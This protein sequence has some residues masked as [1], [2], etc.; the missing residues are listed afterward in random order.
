MSK[1]SSAVLV[2]LAIT[3]SMCG[4]PQATSSLDSAA[5]DKKNKNRNLLYFD[6]TANFKR[7]SFQDSIRYYL[8]KSKDAGV[9]DVVVDVKPI[10][11]EVLYPSKIAPVMNEWA[12][13]TK[14]EKFDLLT[15][16]IQ[17]AHQ[18]GMTVHA[19]TNIFVAGHNHFNRGPVYADP[20]KKNWQ[21]LNYTPQGM[22]PITQ[23][24]TKYSAMVNP[25]L[26]E[27]Q[28]YE[29]SILKEL[30]TRYPKLDGVILD[31]VR[32]DGLESDFSQASRQAFEKH[33]GRP[34]AKFP[35]DIYTYSKD[36]KPVRVPGPLFKQW[37][38]WRAKVIYDFV[39]QA[40]TELK[41]INPKLIFGD[42]TG[43]WYPTYY[44]VGVNWASKEYDPSATYDWA[45]PTYK[46]YGYAEALDLYTTGSYYFEVEKKE[47]KNINVTT[48]NRTEAGQGKGT[49]D[50][51]TV[52]GSAE[53]AMKITKGKVP[54][55]AG[56]YVDQYKGH[57]EQFVKALKMC[58][59][60]SDGAMVFDI[61]HVINEGWWKELKRGL[62]E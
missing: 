45:T 31:R 9:T 53:M 22:T 8:V 24:K 54:V 20:A 44:E 16:F 3:M 29:L 59:A 10:S 50:W 39:Y 17:E 27:V 55:Y 6:A 37:V 34:V 62:T 43:S 18:L 41:K 14:T 23:I 1:Y 38:E 13:F 60:K 30:V 15:A 12:G 49:E 40:R 36:E 32:Y 46:N 4:K 47:A 5:A 58:R 61:V 33:L 2:F 19:S 11:G 21:S 28:Q 25:A 57:S 48:V 42:Y 26:P 7:F 35:A 51:Y 52:E 56:V